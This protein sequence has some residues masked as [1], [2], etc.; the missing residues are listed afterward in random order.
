MITK[1]LFQSTLL[2]RGATT[3]MLI[4]PFKSLLFQST[5]L[6]RGATMSLDM[7]AWMIQFQSTLLMR[8]A[9]SHMTE[10]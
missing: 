4:T 1:K 6:M 9:T 3:V 10:L 8:G 5:L 2:M 7:A